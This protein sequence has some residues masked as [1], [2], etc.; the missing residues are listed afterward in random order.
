MDIAENIYKVMDCK[1]QKQSSVALAAGYSVKRF[2]DM[3]RGRKLIRA[4]DIPKICKG[5]GVSPNE[6]LNWETNKAG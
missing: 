5:L 2:N 4:E 1:H 3:L 6:L